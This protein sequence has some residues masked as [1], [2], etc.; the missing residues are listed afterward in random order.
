MT[1]EQKTK[2]C[3]C[4]KF[5]KDVGQYHKAGKKK[6]GDTRYRSDCKHCCAVKQAE[7]ISKKPPKPRKP[8]RKAMSKEVKDAKN[9][10]K[11]KKYYGA[12]RDR[13]NN[14]MKFLYKCKRLEKKMISNVLPFRQSVFVTQFNLIR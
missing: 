6:N 3:S 4:C 14:R 10:V 1:T 8:K 7:R 13:I 11:C 12:K 9:K 5:T 2:V